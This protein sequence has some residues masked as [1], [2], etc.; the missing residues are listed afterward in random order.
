M[1]APAATVWTS[2][3]SEKCGA[4]SRDGERARTRYPLDGTG[5]WT[6]CQFNE[7][8]CDEPVGSEPYRDAI[9]SVPMGMAQN[10]SPKGTV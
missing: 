4:W 3:D 1:A 7:P 9:H 5:G 6:D 2:G 8:A 10:P